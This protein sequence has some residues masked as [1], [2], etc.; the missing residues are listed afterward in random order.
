VHEEARH[1]DRYMDAVDAHS[2][3]RNDDP[4]DRS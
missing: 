3:Y 2:P 4:P 1:V